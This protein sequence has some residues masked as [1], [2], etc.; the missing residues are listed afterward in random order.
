MK[1]PELI[2]NLVDKVSPNTSERF[3]CPS[4]KGLNT[5]G[6]TKDNGKVIWN[7]F[8]VGCSLRSGVGSYLASTDQLKTHRDRFLEAKEGFSLSDY[9][10]HGLGSENTVKM[11]VDNHCLEVYQ[12]GL[13]DVAYDPQQNRVCFLIKKDGKVVGMAGKAVDRKTK[14]KVLNYPGSDSSTP[15]TCGKT[16]IVVLVEDCLSAASVTRIGGLTGM[17]LLGTSLKTEY[18]PEIKKYDR[19]IVAL[20]RDARKKAL[21]IKKKLCYYC[22]AVD[23]WFLDEDIKNMDEFAI[24]HAYEN[25]RQ[26]YHDSH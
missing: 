18:I 20:D 19:V 2:S 13:F 21:A 9:L 12:K 14:P 6:I 26:A 17:A 15:F 7:C 25:N 22:P 4:C 24:H 8:R 23:I 11:I 1:I 10:I 16:K 5:L 3:N